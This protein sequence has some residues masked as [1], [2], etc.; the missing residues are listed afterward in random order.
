VSLVKV[1]ICGITSLIDALAA[2]DAG[3]D[4]LG[5]VFFEKSPRYVTQEQVRKIVRQIPP[6]VARVGV[7]VN[8]PPEYV[9]R[10]VGACGLTA[11]Q[12]SGDEP[13]DFLGDAPF[14][15]IRT[16]RVRDNGSLSKM[17]AYPPGSAL[18]LDSFQPGVFG[19]S[20]VTFDWTIA[21]K[22]RGTH[23]VIVAGGLTPQNV[24]A[25]IDALKP[26]GVDVSSGVEE[27]PGKKD[28][29]K[30]RRFIDA[31]RDYREKE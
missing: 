11:V 29:E 17:G 28:P 6:F 10:T 26:Y 22:M 15:V 20:G 21:D 18:L 5:F 14:G 27:Q 9:M 19:G 7:F 1:K 12:L 25:A 30:I 4:A 13:V 24:R 31:V 23:R 16:I 3:A 2:V 8:R